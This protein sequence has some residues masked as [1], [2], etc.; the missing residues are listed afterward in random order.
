M[1]KDLI[2]EYLLGF[3]GIV[4]ILTLIIQGSASTTQ[5]SSFHTGLTPKRQSISTIQSHNTEQDCWIIISNNVYNV[6]SYISDHP[7]GRKS[8]RAYC[9]GNATEAFQTKNG[10]GQHSQEADA[11]LQQYIIGTVQ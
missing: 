7:G 5:K 8:I 10:K 6:T 9:G 2:V 3:I 1:K 11:L 4:W